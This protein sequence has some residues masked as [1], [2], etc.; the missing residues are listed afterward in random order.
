MNGD[1]L[2]TEDDDEEVRREQLIIDACKKVFRAGAWLVKNGYGHLGILPY[3]APSGCYW[4]CEF[5]PPGRPSKPFFRYSTCD[6]VRYLANHCGGSIRKDASAKKIAEAIMVSVPEDVR[7]GC[8]GEASME[9][10]RWLDEAEA[11]L[12]AGY[13]PEAFHECTEDYSRWALVRPYG[14]EQLS[15]APMPGYV[16]PGHERKAVDNPFWNEATRRFNIIRKPQFFQLPTKALNDDE[17]C[18]L[19]AKRLQHDIQDGDSFDAMHIFR[20]AL[21]SLQGYESD[22]TANL[23]SPGFT[24]ISLVPASD[25]AIRRA[26]R[27]LSMVHELHKAGY[28]R[29]RIC[30][31]SSYDK[32]SWRCLLM[33]ADN[34]LMD[35]WTP[36][37]SGFCQCYSTANDQSFFDWKDVRHGKCRVPAS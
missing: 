7:E 16:A 34:V 29:L 37:N 21:G 23:V 18:F 9:T 12:Q 17:F 27:L 13:V 4:R 2:E 24:T 30:S 6:E 14:N 5:H 35:G 20:A 36:L 28:Q 3:R 8:Q 22:D 11:H 26:C 31:G 15:M 19:L 32:T 33:S 25:V 10:L 1:E